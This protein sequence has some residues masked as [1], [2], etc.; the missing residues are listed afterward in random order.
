MS[1]ETLDDEE[2]VPNFSGICPECGNT[3]VHIHDLQC[4]IC[5][6]KRVVFCPLCQK[7]RKLKI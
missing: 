6:N 7:H 2:L 4:D 1:F 5:D 3:M